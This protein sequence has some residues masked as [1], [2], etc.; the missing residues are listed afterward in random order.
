[1]NNNRPEFEFVP[2]PAPQSMTI[3]YSGFWDENSLN[4]YIAA[5]HQRAQAA[6]GKSPVRKVLL[7]F[8]QSAIQTGALMERYRE[9]I[10][11]YSGQIEEYGILLPP[12]A[13]LAM[14]IRRMMQG[15]PSRYFNTERE[16]NDWL[17]M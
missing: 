15:T 5:L 14:Q 2:G 7:D 9:L 4:R 10:D 6:G 3:V 1:M 12:S 17:A 11:R 8:R 13:L 16:A